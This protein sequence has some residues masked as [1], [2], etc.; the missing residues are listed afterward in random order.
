M[1]FSIFFR[2]MSLE[3]LRN[4][5]T[6]P[7]SHPR[8]VSCFW[9]SHAFPMLPSKK[10]RI[11][12][13]IDPTIWNSHEQPIYASILQ[14]IQ[15]FYSLRLYQLPA[16]IPANHSPSSPRC[17][18]TIEGFGHICVGGLNHLMHWPC[19]STSKRI[20]IIHHPLR[21]PCNWVKI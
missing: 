17:P 20:I 18:E 10:N 9:K 12:V 3:E 5:H 19:F 14:V 15:S 4:R 11:F 6:D 16:T 2:R 21:Y 7:S 1:G 8:C 13:F